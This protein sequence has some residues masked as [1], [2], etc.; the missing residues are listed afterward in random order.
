MKTLKDIQNMA[1]GD[2]AIGMGAHYRP[3]A[4]LI[5]SRQYKHIVEVGTAYGGNALHML[6][7]TDIDKLVC[8]DPYIY[9]PAMPGFTCQEEYDTLYEFACGRLMR[10]SYVEIIRKTSKDAFYEL[11]TAHDL[12]FLDG[13]HEYEDVKWECE[14]YSKL[15]RAGG[16][17]SGHDYNIFEG[18]NKAVDEFAKQISKPVQQ[19][20]GNI[21]Y[22]NL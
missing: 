3:L 20:H 17:L 7:H 2:Y 5:E 19:L 13:S 15:I 10:W 6:L 11:F 22:F 4:E 12:V 14:N 1:D 21:W 16:V 8:I 18:V 9:Y